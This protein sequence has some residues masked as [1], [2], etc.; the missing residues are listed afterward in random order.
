MGKILRDMQS[1]ELFISTK[2]GYLMWPAPYG[3]G[4]SKKYIV[5]SLDQ[6]LKRLGLEYVDIFYAHWPAPRTPLEETM[7]ALDLMVRQA[8]ALYVG[9]SNFSGDAVR[10]Y[11]AGDTAHELNSDHHPSTSL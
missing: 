3:D 9:M 2:V 4:L 11:S 10:E 1:K 8:K 6:S 5:A 7:A